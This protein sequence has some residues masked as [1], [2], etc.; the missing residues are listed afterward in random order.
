MS[1]LM[2]ATLFFAM[3]LGAQQALAGGA[4]VRPGSMQATGGTPAQQQKLDKCKAQYAA[5][6]ANAKSMNFDKYRKWYCK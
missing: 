3:S 4:M 5:D 1:R 2:S 6:T